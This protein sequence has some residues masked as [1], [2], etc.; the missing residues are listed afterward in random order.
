M[1]AYCGL[2]CDQCP[3]HLAT[4]EQDEPLQKTMRES[5][6]EECAINYGLNLQAEDIN[7][8]DGCT[9]ASGRVFSGCSDCEIRKCAIAKNIENCAF[10]EEYICAKLKELYSLD[11]GAQHRLEDIRNRN[12]N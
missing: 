1:I 4:I 11:P 12:M 9:S 6:A 7:D 3:I 5:I 8:C 10:C 2:V